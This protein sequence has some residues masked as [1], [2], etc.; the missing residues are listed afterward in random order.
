M[1]ASRLVNPDDAPILA[2][3]LRANRDFMA[4]WEPDRSEEFFTDAGQ[5]AGVK[6]AL[7][8]CERG[9]MLPHVILDESGRV[10]GRVTLNQIVRGPFQSCNLGYWLSAADN[11]RGLT[12]AAVRHLLAVAFGE[13]G[14]HRVQAGTLVD[15]VRS[16]RVLDRNGF[17]QFGLAPNYLHIAGSWQDHVLYQVIN[18]RP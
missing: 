13:L 15:N 4:P 10:V 14:L 16:Q 8:R 7:D 3:L 11:G 2:E 18:P 5:L 9:S 6:E 1:D 17:V 12:S